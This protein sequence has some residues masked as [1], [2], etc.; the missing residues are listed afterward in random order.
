MQ[1]VT[2][3]GVALA[4]LLTVGAGQPDADRALP[5][6]RAASGVRSARRAVDRRRRR[7]LA[8][9][10]ITVVGVVFSITIVTLTLASTQFGARTL[11]NVIRHRGATLGTFVATLVSATPVLISIGPA[12]HVRLI[13]AHV[14]DRR[15]VER[16]FE[17]IRH[18]SGACR[19]GERGI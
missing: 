18:A 15:L 10:V 2:A 11:R 12:S 19:P 9:A 3:R 13:T 16:A 7:T 1:T 6:H 5:A 8:A 14:S 17:K 4:R